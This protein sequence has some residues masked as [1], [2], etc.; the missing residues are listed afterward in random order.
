MAMPHNKMLNACQKYIHQ[1]QNLIGT[2]INVFSVTK[3]RSNNL[4]PNFDKTISFLTI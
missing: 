4:I 2:Y 3:K 1:Y